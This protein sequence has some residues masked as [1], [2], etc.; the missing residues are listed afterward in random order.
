MSDAIKLEV[1]PAEVSGEDVPVTVVIPVSRQEVRP[2]ALLAA[3]PLTFEIIL[4]RGGSRASSMNAAAQVARGRHLWF[5]HADTTLK[6]QSVDVLLKRLQEGPEALR[7]FELR[8][9]GGPLMCLTEAGVWF[10]CRALGIPFGDQALCL[11]QKWFKALGGYDE[12]AVHGEDHLL[13]RQARRA[14][15]AIRPVG[16]SVF[17]SARKYRLNGWFRTT[18]RHWQLTVQQ[19]WRCSQGD[20]DRHY[21]QP[22]RKHD[23]R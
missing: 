23:V 18:W 17:T 21:R 16:Q 13:V 10:R 7:Y 4:A 1:R 5:V 9:D 8:F 19:A 20:M 22:R 15:L 12:T 2:D 14:G 6:A 3:L 11:P